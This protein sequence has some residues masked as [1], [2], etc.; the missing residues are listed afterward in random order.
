LQYVAAKLDIPLS[1]VYSFA[2]FYGLFN[3][4]PQR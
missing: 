2:P 4:E 3:L 1:R